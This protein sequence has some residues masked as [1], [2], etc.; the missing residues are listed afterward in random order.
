MLVVD[1][2]QHLVDLTP[3]LVGLPV[4]SLTLL[5]KPEKI[6]AWSV[7]RDQ[8][9]GEEVNICCLRAVA[10]VVARRAG[11]RRIFAARFAYIH[12]GVSKEGGGAARVD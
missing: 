4:G 8:M 11:R 12:F 1:G 5:A 6:S 10:C 9:F 3:L 2:V 7:G